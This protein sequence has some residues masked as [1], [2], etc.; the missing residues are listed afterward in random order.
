MAEVMSA[1]CTVCGKIFEGKNCVQKA[2]EHEKIPVEKTIHEIG[3]ILVYPKRDGNF[4]VYIISMVYIGEYEHKQVYYGCNDHE[5]MFKLQINNVDGV[6]IVDKEDLLNN[7]YYTDLR[8]KVMELWIH[9][10]FGHLS[11]SMDHYGID[12]I[13][14]YERR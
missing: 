12:N 14:G 13:I 11:N 9:N 2:E 5:N 10:L 4:N 1:K 6:R 7:P 8:H 3:D